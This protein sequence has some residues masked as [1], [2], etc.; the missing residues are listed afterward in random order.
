MVAKVI[1]DVAH[2]HVDSPY[3]YDIPK[4]LETTVRVGDLVE[5][6]FHH[7]IR[8]AMVIKIQKTS[9]QK[10]RKTIHQKLTDAPPL[11]P[12]LLE[13]ALRLNKQW[14]VP[15]WS[16]LRLFLPNNLL[17]KKR[18]MIQ[19]KPQAEARF[20]APFNDQETVLKRT[21]NDQALLDEGL[22]KGVYTVVHTL[23]PRH[24]LPTVLWAQALTPPPHPTPLQATLYD[25]LAAL[26]SGCE[27]Q[28]LT[29][30][31]GTSL[32]SLKRLEHHGH[33]RLERRL[34][35]LEPLESSASFPALNTE[36]T[37]ALDHLL[38]TLEA[39][40]P[41]VLEGRH[42]SGKTLVMVHAVKRLVEEKKNCIIVVPEGFLLDDLSD[43]L[44]AALDVPFARLHSNL[45]DAQMYRQW[46]AVKSGEVHCVIGTRLALFAPFDDVHAI[47]C[48]EAHHPTHASTQGAL[49]HHLDVCEDYF[50]HHQIPTVYLSATPAVDHVVALRQNTLAYA[51]LTQT[52]LSGH[53]P[54]ITTVDLRAH[55]T[56]D[57]PL[58]PPLIEAIKEALKSDYKT[59]LWLNRKGQAQSLQCP[60]CHHTVLCEDCG[61]PLQVTPSRLICPKCAKRTSV[62]TQC[63]HDA[64]PLETQGLGLD[65]L[66][67]TVESLFPNTPVALLDSAHPR[68]DTQAKIIVG[69]QLLA[70]GKDWPDVKVIGVIDA[71]TLTYG[72]EVHRAHEAFSWLH[73]LAGRAGRRSF[74]S[75]ML[76]QTYQPNHRIFQALTSGDDERFYSEE[77]DQRSLLSLPPFKQMTRM[78]L[79]HAD[80]AVLTRVALSARQYA[81]KACAE[82]IEILGPYAVYS[83][84]Q[85]A[86]EITFKGDDLKPTYATFARMVQVFSQD[87]TIRLY[88]PR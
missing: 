80:E 32:A 15:L 82:S 71:D 59:L 86:Q 40:Q 27:A 67:T 11:P 9:V 3:D 2:R 68:I 70:H 30:E 5:V 61:V 36:Q 19:V 63:P 87:V 83:G 75:A 31:H 13:L 8:L 38:K 7:Q 25:H 81:L 60:T 69:T 46:W 64:T 72:S 20:K 35:P 66:K 18:A 28:R 84:T 22:E 6:S 47:F 26:P 34:Q 51:R 33:V 50:D 52:P 54:V 55:L 16:Y 48:E 79:H 14:A 37:T 78:R 73:H 24:A 56:Q 45:T 77:I 58:S 4:T 53:P 10:N 42:N 43:R 49:Y 29:H 57:T 12:R 62:P 41:L 17:M 44:A 85:R 39:R 1:V 21:F 23:E 76:I 74:A 88:H 65:S